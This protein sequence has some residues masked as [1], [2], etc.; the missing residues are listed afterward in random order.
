MTYR[1][2]D[3]EAEEV[4]LTSAPGG[5]IDIVFTSRSA[6]VAGGVTDAAGKPVLDYTAVIFPAD[7]GAPP[8]ADYQR[9]QTAQ[10]DPQ[11]RFRA[12]A[13]SR[14]LPRRGGR[15]RDLQEVFEP[16]FLDG[17]RRVAKPLRSREDETV[18]VQLTLVPVP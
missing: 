16:E 18:T 12:G 10:P 15:R 2:R 3:V 9:R 17:L 6:S 4:D 5:R 1:G 14:R 7:A 13:A 8:G 11:G